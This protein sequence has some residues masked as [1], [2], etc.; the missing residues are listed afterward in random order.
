MAHVEARHAAY[1]E[2]NDKD[3]VRDDGGV[4][5]ESKDPHFRA[6]Q[7]KRVWGELYKVS[8]ATA[9]NYSFHSD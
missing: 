3:L 8:I 7:S 9:S 1:D 4:K 2:A 5:D 6:G